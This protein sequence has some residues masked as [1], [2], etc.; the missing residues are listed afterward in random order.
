MFPQKNEFFLNKPIKNPGT[1]TFVLEALSLERIVGRL[2]VTIDMIRTVAGLAL[3]VRCSIIYGI[4][5][6]S[7]SYGDLC[8]D[9][10][11]DKF[12]FSPENCPPELNELGIDCTCPF[13]IPTQ[14][15]DET[16]EYDIP[17]YCGTAV[18]SL[19]NG[20][21]DVRVII[22]NA[23]NQHTACFRFLYTMVRA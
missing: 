19:V 1:E 6:G 17:D 8:K 2:P 10:M 22:N 14:T 18:S 5:Y 13:N 7:C 11:Q 9:I 15:I 3:P 20:D 4:Y 16:F 21:F 23:L 12:E